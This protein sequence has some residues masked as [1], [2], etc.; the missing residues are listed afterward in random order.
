MS[1]SDTPRTDQF[2]WCDS[3]AEC[4]VVSASFARELEK[5][6]NKAN[7]TIKTLREQLEFFI[8]EGNE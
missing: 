7:E 4:D 6:L 8:G 3:E 1:K 2:V 5:E